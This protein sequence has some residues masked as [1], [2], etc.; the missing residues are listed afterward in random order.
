[1]TGLATGVASAVALPITGIAVGT[2]QL[3][4]GIVNSAEAL[5]ATQVGMLWDE[6]KREWLYFSLDKEMEN[7]LLQLEAEKLFSGSATSG[8]E[9]KVKDRQYYDLLEVSTG[10]TS[11]E[12]KKAY[13]KRSRQVHPDRNPDDPESARKFQELSHA[14]QV[15]SNEQ[16]RAAYDKNGKQESAEMNLGDI[17]PFVFFNTMFGSLAVQ[18]YIGELWIAN[19]ASSLMKDQSLLD[20]AQNEGNFDQDAFREKAV[21]RGAEEDLTQ[22]KR[23]VECALFLRQRITPFVNDAIDE[24]EFIC[25]AQ[26]EAANITKNSF[27]EIFL[28]AIGFALEVEAAEFLGGFEG[29]AAKLKKKGYS[30]TNQ[31]KLLS[32]GISAAR[33]GTQ[34]YKDMESLQ[35]KDA[36]DLSLEEDTSNK[37]KKPEMDE[38]QRMKLAA[39]KLEASLP[40]FLDLAWAINIQ[41]ITRTLKNVCRFLFHDEAETILLETRLKRAHAVHLLGREFHVMGKLAETTS[42]TCV[43]AQALRTRAEVAAMTTLA[44][45]QGQDVTD[46]DAEEMIRQ[47][48]ELEDRHKQSAEKS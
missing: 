12:L 43:D 41:D 36:E 44:K 1:V 9:R 8:S 30:F 17:D 26:A 46:K 13:Y 19:K 5:R 20:L 33:A 27:G 31:F 32:A 10:A 2:Y 45:A 48:R 42:T 14:Y 40:A 34:A 4:R 28:V 6:E 39:D 16:T 3:G 15:L 24:A 18:P 22:R 29:Q 7:I 35:N 11:A 25:G 37:E 21:K 38:K 23:E 47:A